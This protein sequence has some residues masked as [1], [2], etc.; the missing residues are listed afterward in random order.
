VVRLDDGFEMVVADIPGLIEGA[1]EGKGLGH[2][3]LRHVERARG[4]V[5]LLDLAPMDGRS[6]TEQERILLDE[7]GRYQADLLDRP[8]VSVGSRADLEGQL[9]LD[10][11]TVSFDGLRIS[12]V[13]GQ[14]LNEVLGAMRALVEEARA[15]IEEPEA[16]VVHRPAGEGV[17][18]ERGDDGSWVVRGRQAER[19]VNLS[20]LTNLDALDY[21]QGRLK[22]LGVNTALARAGV[23]TGDTVHIGRMTFEYEPDD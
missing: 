23:E 8:R 7:L 21:A 6:P 2:Q 11:D 16:F 20:D 1:A 9:G 13:T 18:V 4:L 22:K 19:A 17:R 15:T 12:G 5:V 10:V 14:G 3:F